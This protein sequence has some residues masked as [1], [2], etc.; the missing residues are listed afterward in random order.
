MCLFLWVT[1]T[2]FIR[3]GFQLVNS[4]NLVVFFQFWLKI[5]FHNFHVGIV[6]DKL[7]R[8]MF[9]ELSLAIII[10]LLP[11]VSCYC[12]ISFNYERNTERDLRLTCRCN[13][14]NILCDS[15]LC[16]CKEVGITWSFYD[17]VQCMIITAFL[18]FNT[19]DQVLSLQ[20]QWAWVDG[21]SW[22]VN[23]LHL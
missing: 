16:D 12:M 17:A 15:I 7:Y 1:T 11:F 13:M 21:I 9:S 23:Q 20:Y 6:F 18:S 5:Y 8:H 3:E 19:R 22:S 4:R 14:S 10:M 2:R